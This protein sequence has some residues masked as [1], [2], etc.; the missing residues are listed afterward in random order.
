MTRAREGLLAVVLAHQLTQAVALLPQHSLR[1]A[2][3]FADA[4]R[5][6]QNA[7][8]TSHPEV[9]EAMQAD[10]AVSDAVKYRIIFVR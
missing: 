10:Q 7:M 9:L 8:S 3:C 6:Q 5:A 2:A 4:N 1:R